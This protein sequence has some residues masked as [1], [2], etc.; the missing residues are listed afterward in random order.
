MLPK[1]A[2]EGSD[3]SL[4]RKYEN[5]VL[6]CVTV[7]GPRSG[8]VFIFSCYIGLAPASAVLPPQIRNTPSPQKNVFLAYPPKIFYSVP[9][10]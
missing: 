2:I 3:K 10:P 7:L 8:G 4:A 6:D 5:P 9:Y 1:V